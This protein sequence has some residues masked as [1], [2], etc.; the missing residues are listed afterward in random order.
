MQTYWVW[1]RHGN[2]QFNFPFTYLFEDKKWAPRNDVFLRDPASG[3]LP[4]VWNVN[5]VACHATAAQPRQDPRTAVIDTRL[6]EAGISCEA[7]HGPAETHVR[8]NVDPARRYAQRRAEEPDPTITN[9]ARLGQVKT[10]EACG[11]CHAIRSKPR[12]DQWLAEGFPFRPGE[13]IETCAPLV[14]YDPAEWDVPGK[15]RKRWL[16]EGSFWPDGMVRVSGREFN[17]LAASPCYQRGQLSCLS[18]HSMH[19]YANNDDQLAVKMESNQA[20][21]QCH[22]TYDAKLEEHTRHPAGSSGSLCYNCHMPHTTYGLLKAIRSHH[23]D[24]P[25]VQASLRTGRPNA[26]NLCH[27]DRSLG[28]T[29]RKISEWYGQPSPAVTTEQES[30]SAAVTWLLS[31]DA[32]QR[33]L[34]AWHAGWE[35]AQQTAGRNWLAPYV[36]QLLEDPYSVV[37][38]IAHRSLTRLPGFADFAYDYIGPKADRTAARERALALWRG[39]RRPGD[40]RPEVLLEANGALQEQKFGALLKRRDDRSME[41]LE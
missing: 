1:S 40:A 34:L 36:A 8:A 33:A 19:R 32:G 2:M 30:I 22:S 29:A 10:S 25:S 23:I 24:S 31:G 35:P 38:Y 4:Q 13:E 16:M 20:C 14:L 37:R 5:C 6:A 15:E 12:Y 21:V 26:C 7:C 18:C 28:W 41:L 17:G 39:Q 3:L 27:L 11:Q 9:P